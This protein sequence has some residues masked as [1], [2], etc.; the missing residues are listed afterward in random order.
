MS[1]HIMS[2]EAGKTRVL[3]TAGQYCDKDIMVTAT[4]GDYEKGY[5]DGNAAGIEAGKQAQ[6]DAHWDAYQQNGNRTGYDYGFAG[7]GWTD[8]TFKPKYDIKVVRGNYL[9][10]NCRITDLV[11]L[12]KDCGVVIDMS[13][14]TVTGYF[15]Q[16]SPSI[17]TIPVMDLRNRPQVSYFIHECSALRSIEKIIL[18]EDGSQTFNANSFGKLPALEEIRFEGLIGHNLEIKDSPLLSEASLD[19]ILTHF[20]DCTGQTSLV[21]TVHPNVGARLTAYQQSVASTL[22]ITIAY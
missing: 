1:E 6:Y 16:N 14:N 8:E 22:N 3:H 18:K 17:Q 9:F 11:K 15:V 7:E 2:I 10:A 19:S 5:Q 12:L 21:L 20:K 13:Q 4:G